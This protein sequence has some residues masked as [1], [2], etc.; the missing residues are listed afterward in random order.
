VLSVAASEKRHQKSTKQDDF[1]GDH[2]AS[3][4][5]DRLI[6]EE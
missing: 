3:A 4:T 5:Q 6:M 1:Q 2:V